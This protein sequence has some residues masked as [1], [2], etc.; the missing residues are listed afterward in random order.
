VR[1]A[2]RRSV[3]VAVAIGLACGGLAA[4]AA[5]DR[6]QSTGARC[7][8]PAVGKASG[9]VRA[10]ARDFSDV[11]RDGDRLTTRSGRTRLEVTLSPLAITV[12]TRKGAIVREVPD[13]GLYFR[14]G[15]SSA[16]V[17]VRAAEP[18]NF[19]R[20]A[21][22]LRATFGDGTTGTVTLQAHADD[23]VSVALAF[24]DP[25]IT[26]W[27]EQLAT[28]PDERVYGLTERIVD[29]LSASEL[30][31]QPVGTLNRKGERVS[32][33]VRPTIS[34]YAPFYQSSNG[35]G[36]FVDGSMPGVYDLGATDPAVLSFEY[37]IDPQGHAGRYFVF[38]GDHYR[39]NDAYSRL[40]G[41]PFV[42]PKKVFLHWR[43]RDQAVI[44]EPVDVDG[45]P[46]NP[47]V[48]DDLLNYERYDIPVGIYHF[49]RPWAVGT[50]GYGTLRFDPAR[51][52]DADGMLEVMKRRGWSSQVWVS[53][54]AL[55]ER[56]AR[57]REQGWLA[58]GSER[59]LDLTNPAAV[60]GLERDLR[61]FLRGSGRLV[62]GFF[63][64]RSEEIVPSDT[65]DVYHDGRNGR[66]VHNAYPVLLQQ[67][68]RRALDEA[69]G[70]DG[71][72]IARAAYSGSARYAMTWGGDTHS[73]E[74][75]LIPEQPDTGPST[76][77]GLRSVLV[78]LQRCAFMGM[79]YWGSDIGGYSDF[80][81]REVFARWIEVGALSPLMR[82]HGKGTD[83]PWDMPTE[84]KVDQEMIDIYRRY[85]VL[86]HAL[87]DY[88]QRLARDAHRTGAPLVRP[89]VFN[90]PDDPNVADR[91]DQW[92]LGN[93]LLVAP[94]WQ[95]GGRSRAVYLPKGKWVD[96][97]DRSRV[98]EGPVEL[99]E[100]VP[101][102]RVPLFV[103]Q[104]SPLLRDPHLQEVA[105][106]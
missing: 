4:P 9:A 16:P 86:H 1:R 97:W 68:V 56:A 27:G 2:R 43:G 72:A 15:D 33:Y 84:P 36:L 20:C 24:E 55:D 38:A 99:T 73:R 102:G 50:E 34:A 64:D 90:Y 57:A 21:L 12:S 29:D 62:D 11:N 25:T 31:P 91:W 66:Q 83:A 104:G 8:D 17:P 100:D 95:S 7:G 63:V 5:A 54:W 51:F 82:F 87:A 26:H 46:V 10:P 47:T 58:P 94:V 65:D 40:T 49:D 28:S 41:R 22:Q 103:K 80:G 19:R 70:G 37:E 44:G 13:G 30:T 92:L 32:M 61:G 89:L 69:R 3:A 77:L 48:A 52:P 85:V 60:R 76:D 81:D 79:P 42:P 39:Q 93:D 96:F 67:A 23:T 35:Y 14:R 88:Q 6:A 18:A 74:G 106:Q 71:W 78:S 105:R 75:V 59:E 101:L 45:V 53:E 98:V